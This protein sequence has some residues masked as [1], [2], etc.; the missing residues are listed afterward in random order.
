MR[1]RNKPCHMPLARVNGAYFLKGN[2]TNVL[3]LKN[4]NLP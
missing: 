1:G 2:L 4:K 3:Q